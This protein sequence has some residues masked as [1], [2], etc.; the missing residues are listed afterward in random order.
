MATDGP[1]LELGIGHYSTPILHYIC[2]DRHLVSIDNNADWVNEF[3]SFETP[4]HRICFADPIMN[5]VIPEAFSVVF[6]DTAP[7]TSRIGLIRDFADR[8]QYLVIHDTECR[9]YRYDRI[10]GLF[11]YLVDVTRYFPGAR[12][13]SR[14]NESAIFTMSLTIAHCLMS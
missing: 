5:A 1:V 2:R 7:V 11:N 12:L 10:W 8:A 9:R 4:T 14:T 13:E 3:R 6:V